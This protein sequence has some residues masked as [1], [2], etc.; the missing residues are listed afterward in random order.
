MWSIIVFFICWYEAHNNV[1]WPAKNFTYFAFLYYSTYPLV[2]IP[3]FII[4]V[5]LIFFLE[6]LVINFFRDYVRLYFYFTG[7][8]IN[9]GLTLRALAAAFFGRFVEINDDRMD[10]RFFHLRTSFWSKEFFRLFGKVF[11][12][13]FKMLVYTFFFLCVTYFIHYFNITNNKFFSNIGKFKNDH[14][15]LFIDFLASYEVY[16]ATYFTILFVFYPLF[17]CL[18]LLLSLVLNWIQ[19]KFLLNNPKSFYLFYLM[20][21]VMFVFNCFMSNV[22]A[23]FNTYFRWYLTDMLKKHCEIMTN[24]GYDDM[25][26]RTKTLPRRENSADNIIIWNNFFEEISSFMSSSISFFSLLLAIVPL[27]LLLFATTYNNF[28]VNVFFFFIFGPNYKKIIFYF[29]YCLFVFAIV[30]IIIIQIFWLDILM[31][32]YFIYYVAWFS[33]NM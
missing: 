6:R 19:N 9:Y 16:R 15:D 10:I 7:K 23:I 5:I 18:I 31:R 21:F 32:L 30:S 4:T 8:I 26:S 11:S 24:T 2:M 25:P 20:S 3:I 33:T 22:S 17:V 12:T 27:S 1:V 13:I 28:F 14:W 29:A